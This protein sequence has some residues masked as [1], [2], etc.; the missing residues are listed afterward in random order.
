MA[1]K[2]NKLKKTQKSVRDFKLKAHPRSD[3]TGTRVPFTIRTD[4][5]LNL[6]IRTAH[7]RKVDGRLGI[8]RKAKRILNELVTELGGPSAITAKQRLEI[9]IVLRQTL[10][11]EGL[12][13]EMVKAQAKGQ[14]V[15]NSFLPI[16]SD[17]LLMQALDRAYK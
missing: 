9:N 16:Q 6:D 10:I 3:G 8:Y 11:S 5:N 17:R 15:G 12:F 4:E 7:G 13:G 2:R 1:K 14:D